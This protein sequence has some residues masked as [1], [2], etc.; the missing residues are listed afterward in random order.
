[1]LFSTTITG[2][3]KCQG[4][5]S[6]IILIMLKIRIDESKLQGTTSGNKYLENYLT[7]PFTNSSQTAERNY[8][9]S[10]LQEP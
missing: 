4:L 10:K 1:M 8:F 3:T 7:S 2:G 9:S 6:Q 5:H